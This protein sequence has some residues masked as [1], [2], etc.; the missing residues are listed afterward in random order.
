MNDSAYAKPGF[1]IVSEGFSIHRLPVRRDDESKWCSSCLTEQSKGFW[2]YA[3][4]VIGMESIFVCDGC[5]SAAKTHKFIKGG[6]PLEK[7]QP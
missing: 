6:K 2:M 1:K 4:Q 7:G 3:P 5:L